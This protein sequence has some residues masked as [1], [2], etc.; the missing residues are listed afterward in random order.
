MPGVPHFLG[1]IFQLQMVG[2]SAPEGQS[3]STAI[4]GRF[5]FSVVGLTL[6][7]IARRD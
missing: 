1:R 5:S 7:Q 6:V 3:T 4:D 2:L